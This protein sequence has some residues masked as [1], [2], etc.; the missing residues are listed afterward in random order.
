MIAHRLSYIIDM[1]IRIYEIFRNKMGT[2]MNSYIIET[3]KFQILR[4]VVSFISFSPGFLESFQGT[5]RPW[6]V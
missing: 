3:Y 5:L 6:Y 4:F 1:I 2:L